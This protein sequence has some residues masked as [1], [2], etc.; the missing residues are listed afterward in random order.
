MADD[1]E[2]L[3]ARAWLHN[4]DLLIGADGKD[5]PLE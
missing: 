4:W 3:M 1:V 2:L 5:L